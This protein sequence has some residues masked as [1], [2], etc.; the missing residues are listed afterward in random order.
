MTDPHRESSRS[1]LVLTGCGLGAYWLGLFVLT[2]LPPEWLFVQLPNASAMLD[3]GGDKPV[4]LLAYAGLA[5]LF[6]SWLTLRY[7]RDARLYAI[8]AGTLAVYSVLDELLQ[9]PVRRTADIWDCC[10]DGIGIALGL[11][12]HAILVSFI[13][14]RQPARERVRRD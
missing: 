3:Q 1:L 14:T 5:F 2:H 7:G 4:H 6:I 9:I 12:V 8:A 13:K 11:A 10:A